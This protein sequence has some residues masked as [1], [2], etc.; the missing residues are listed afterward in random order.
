MSLRIL[1]P[2]SV[3]RSDE[4]EWAGW[5]AT[6]SQNRSKIRALLG[7]ACA[8]AVFVALYRVI[9]HFQT[10]SQPRGISES[11]VSGV[12]FTY[13][14]QLMPQSWGVAAS[15]CKQRGGILARIDSPSQNKEVAELCNAQ[16]C[17]LGYNEQQKVGS[18]AWTHRRYSNWGPGYPD[19]SSTHPEHCAYMYGKLYPHAEKHGLWN[20]KSCT[21]RF[22]SV[23]AWGDGMTKI[24]LPP[25]AAPTQP[26]RVCDG[27]DGE[28]CKG[29]GG[30][31]V[32]L[33]HP[34]PACLQQPAA[35]SL[36]IGIIGDFGFANE[37]EDNV[38]SLL[39]AVEAALS[40]RALDAVLSLGDNGYWD[41]SCDALAQVSSIFGDYFEAG[42][43]TSA[44]SAAV[45]SN[46]FW[47][48]LGNH[49]WDQAPK[50]S[51]MPF[52]RVF[53]YLSAVDIGDVP[54]FED[55]AAAELFG[56]LR[57]QW[58][59]RGFGS[60]LLEIFCLNSN[61]GNP[62]TATPVTRALHDAQ[63]RWVQ[64]KLKAATAKWKIVFFHHPPYTTSREDSAWMQ[65][66]YHKWG[67][68][69]V[70]TGHMHTYE[71]IVQEQ[72]VFVINGLGG[73][74]WRYQVHN[75]KHVASGSVFRYNSDH[76]MMFATVT[77]DE[78]RFCFLAVGSGEPTVIDHF[79]LP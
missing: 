62:E 43:C 67:A 64:D 15:S 29:L 74:P 33:K 13:E 20:D 23:C 52:L 36:T 58:Y 66:A 68:S 47:P 38:A 75:C 57:G 17:W 9:A 30:A 27:N 28:R 46:R 41:G 53:N 22:P 25:T 8:V 14:L 48:T 31:R 61:L 40:P 77:E 21:H 65:H 5:E 34:L 6:F 2:M 72:G 70:M 26:R 60:G 16:R 73:H 78:M 3:N 50:N 59:S 45:G 69:I 76:G 79:A 49:D 18:W 1:Q 54:G 11:P 19:G 55:A 10:P 12:K 71:R 44:S 4:A 24:P 39:Q 37:C 35:G 56:Q 32:R 51:S 63:I 42:N 7:L